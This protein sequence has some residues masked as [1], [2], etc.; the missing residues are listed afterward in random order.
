M[1]G[2][3]RHS[4]ASRGFRPSVPKSWKDRSLAF[5]EADGFGR[6][7]RPGATRDGA[8]ARHRRRTRSALLLR[9]IGYAILFSLPCWAVIFIVVMLLT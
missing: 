1:A 9:G 3:N 6:A 5:P 8:T 7:R 4:P 2:P